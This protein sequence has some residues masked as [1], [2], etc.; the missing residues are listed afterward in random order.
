MTGDAVQEHVFVRLAE[1]GM[2]ADQLTRAVLRADAEA[3]LCSD[4]D[5]P[6]MEGLSRWG[7]TVRFLREELVP[8]GW[9]YDN[10]KQFCR[11]LHP[12]GEF[13]IVV[14]SGDQHTGVEGPDPST[15]YPKGETA[16][17]AVEM[18][19]QLVLWAL[20]GQTD[21]DTGDDKSAAQVKRT[22]Y[23]LYRV[24]TNLIYLELCLPTAIEDGLIRGCDER[25]IL[26]P[27]QRHED[28][29]LP[30]EESGDGGY[31]VDVAAR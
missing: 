20:G 2:S 4:L 12:S 24:T 18:N 22:W 13:A 3:K 8:E 5:P 6:T 27:V 28:P 21:D 1:L 10:P 23:L 14:S 29:A 26:P 16:L 17:R 11:T 7:R 25:I 9:G 30:D 19:G 31:T 15:K